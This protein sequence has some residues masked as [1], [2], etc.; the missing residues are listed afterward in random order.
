MTRRAHL[1]TGVLTDL[2]LFSITVRNLALDVK[3]MGTLF[4]L[5]ILLNSLYPRV[6]QW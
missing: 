2:R 4:S 6:V 5:R 3:D 1:K